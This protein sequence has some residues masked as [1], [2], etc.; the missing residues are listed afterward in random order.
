LKRIIN[1]APVT[2]SLPIE[3]IE[4][5]RAAGIVVSKV[6]RD[7]L[8]N[9]LDGEAVS[10]PAPELVSRVELLEEQI[11]ELQAWRDRVKE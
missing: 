6:C 11:D 10:P 2:I 5:A 9:R 8:Q 7:A 3:L 4:R 1:T